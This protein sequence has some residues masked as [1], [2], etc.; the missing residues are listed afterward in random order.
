[1]N[2][3]QQP[4]SHLQPLPLRSANGDTLVG[5][6]VATLLMTFSATAL[7][8]LLSINTMENSS[9][10]NK[11]DV[12]ASAREAMDRIG[13]LVRTARSVGDVYGVIPASNDPEFDPT[14]QRGPTTAI[15]LVNF[16]STANLINGSAFL[17]SPSFPSAG[18]PYYGNGNSPPQGWPNWPSQTGVT[19]TSPNRYRLSGDTL[20]IQVPVFVKRTQ[21]SAT[22]P[23]VWPVSWNGQPAGGANGS[24]QA[25]DTYVFRVIPD[26][27]RAGTFKMQQACFQAA[28]PGGTNPT[29]VPSSTF[30]ANQLGRETTG[31]T[32]V[33]SGGSTAI[34]VLSGIVGPKD[35][36]GNLS[37]FK[38]VERVAN[39][40]T[41]SPPEGD[42]WLTDYTGVIVDMEVRKAEE[43]IR[44]SVNHFRSEFYFRNNTQTT[45]MGKPSPG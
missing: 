3:T 17:F 36:D 20:I 24:L 9:F 4:K 31:S 43:G 1:M 40:C 25:M 27:A 42:L 28:P 12:T 11:A 26:P 8:A 32:A 30:S 2:R 13:R 34:T 38:Y 22:E 29:G 44:A 16:T 14:I 21:G 7:L 10:W 5:L 35:A 23:A 18:D 45:L 15:N 37:I 41:T 6:L 33:P 19:L 39:S